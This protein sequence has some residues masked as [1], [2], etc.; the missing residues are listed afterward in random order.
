MAVRIIDY[1]EALN[2]QHFHI[3]VNKQAQTHRTAS[4]TK[5]ID[6]NATYSRTPFNTDAAA[7]GDQNY[8]V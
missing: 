7:D 5:V 4:P 1:V 6:S 3:I 2:M 8:G